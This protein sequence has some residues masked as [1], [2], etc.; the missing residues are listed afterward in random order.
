MQIVPLG[1]QA[2]IPEDLEAA[3]SLLR[4][5]FGSPVTVSRA[6]KSTQTNNHLPINGEVLAVV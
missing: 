4:T 5:G 6:V 3:E 2:T 1:I